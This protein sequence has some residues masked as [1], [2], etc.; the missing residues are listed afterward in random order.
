MSL[1]QFQIEHYTQLLAGTPTFVVTAKGDIELNPAKRFRRMR[2]FY[3]KKE[4]KCTSL[5]S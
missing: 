3:L 1:L 2:L 5:T 4:L